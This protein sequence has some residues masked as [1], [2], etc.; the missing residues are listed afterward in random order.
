MIA[1]AFKVSHHICK[2]IERE[3]IPSKFGYNNYW[4]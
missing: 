3:L 4:D 2:D 1:L